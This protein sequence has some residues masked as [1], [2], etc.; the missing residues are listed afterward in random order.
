MSEVSQS[1]DDY[2]DV[3][4]G[5]F[6]TRRYCKVEAWRRGGSY[7]LYI[8]TRDLET[9]TLTRLF[10]HTHTHTHTHT[11]IYKS[12]LV[13][14]YAPPWETYC[15]NEKRTVADACCVDDSGRRQFQGKCAVRGE[16][17]FAAPRMLSRERL[18]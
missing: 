1:Y 17:A 15:G 2:Y 6:S 9:H 16:I 3:V 13:N 12:T 7:I 14:I 18:Q 10:T 4:I 5:N 11:T 8:S